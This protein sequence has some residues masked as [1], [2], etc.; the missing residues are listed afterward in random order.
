VP[1]TPPQVVRPSA[2]ATPA[3]RRWH[4]LLGSYANPLSRIVVVATAVLIVIGGTLHVINLKLMHDEALA[5]TKSE[6]RNLAHVL[7][8]HTARALEAADRALLAAVEVY[9]H[10]RPEDVSKPHVHDILQGIQN[11]SEAVT[12]I[13]WINQVG[14]R[15]ASSTDDP[16]EMPNFAANDFFRVHTLDSHVGF[17]ISRPYKPVTTNGPWLAAVS[18]RLDNP[19]GSFAGI[20]SGLLDPYYFAKFYESIDIG[21]TRRAA[22]ILRDGTILS[23]APSPD[24]AIGR[25]LLDTDLFRKHLPHAANGTFLSD[26][27]ADQIDR[28]VSYSSVTGYPLIVTVGVAVDEALTGW[29]RQVLFTSS[30]FL[31]FLILTLAVVRIL[32]RQLER[33]EGQRRTLDDARRA[34]V[35]SNRAKSAFLSHMSHELRT[36]L[37]AILGFAELIRDRAAA[38]RPDDQRTFAAEIHTAGAHLLELINDILD[39]AKIEA[40]RRRLEETTLDV[41]SLVDGVLRQH[42]PAAARAGVTL[43][44][45]IPADFPAL[46]ADERAVIQMLN[47]LVTNAIKFTPKGGQVEILG[48]HDASGMI[49]AVRDTGIGIPLQDQRRV[50]ERFGHSTDP[51]SHSPQGGTGLGLAIVKGLVELHGG[52][53]NLASTPG[54]GTTVELTFPVLRIANGQAAA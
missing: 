34:A 5:A 43:A 13:A 11:R 27:A 30:G 10:T 42:G 7:A 33:D 22:L 9:Q 37:N 1:F 48:A 47:N 46:L 14:Q 23:R 49:L 8:E 52:R 54:E 20:V 35:E 29:Y 31:A 41:A 15:I 50:F 17:Y 45:T 24:Q 44:S 3:P 19:D 4:R 40:R 26:A 6:T 38:G 36:P 53:V 16:R 32:V 28:I 39:F 21:R 25:S 51:L 2:P 18:R 12:R